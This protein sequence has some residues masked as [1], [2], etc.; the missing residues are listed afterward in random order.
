MICRSYTQIEEPYNLK[1]FL[2]NF[3]WKL[4][5]ANFHCH[6]EGSE[7]LFDDISKCSRESKYKS[8]IIYRIT[9]NSD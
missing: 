3:N 2:G 8:G 5:L 9:R 6:R 4:Y 1:N 7:T